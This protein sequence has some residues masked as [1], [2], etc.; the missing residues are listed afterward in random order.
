MATRNDGILLRH[1]ALWIRLAGVVSICSG[2][3]GGYVWLLDLA[4]RQGRNN[5]RWGFW[6]NPFMQ[7]PPFCESFL[8]LSMWVLLACS[9]A[10]GLGG[11]LLL[12]PSKFGAS[13]VI[14]Q[15]R[16]SIVINGVIAFYIVVAFFAFGRNSS[17]ELFVGDSTYEALA[18]RLGSI[19]AD[20]VLWMFLSSAAVREFFA[21][22]SH[23]QVRGFEVIVQQSSRAT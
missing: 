20:L 12:V 23:R 19:A 10:A 16:T 7:F 1:L 14:W 8:G 6:H 18:L 11:I 22:Q 2:L 3:I 13:L 21:R 9:A 17:D 4:D 15:A 5:L